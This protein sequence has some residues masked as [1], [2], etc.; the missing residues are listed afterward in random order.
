[1]CRNGP[2]FFRLHNGSS[3][4]LLASNVMVK[5]ALNDFYGGLSSEQ[6]ARFN[7]LAGRLAKTKTM[8]LL[9]AILAALPLAASFVMFVTHVLWGATTIDEMHVVVAYFA[10]GHSPRRNGGY[11]KQ[12]FYRRPHSQHVWWQPASALAT[13]HT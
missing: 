6:K 5:P 10:L 13:P 11:R 12:C 3:S 9:I 4:L 2:I 8:A 7:R 1:M